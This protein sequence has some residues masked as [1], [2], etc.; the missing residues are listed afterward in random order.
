MPPTISSVCKNP[1]G[2]R[3]TDLPEIK[4]LREV[5]EWQLYVHPLGRKSLG[6]MNDTELYLRRHPGRGSTHTF[7]PSFDAVKCAHNTTP[8]NALNIQ[9]T[10]FLHP[11]VLWFFIHIN[12]SIF[13]CIRN[14]AL[15]LPSLGHVN[16]KNTNNLSESSLSPSSF[17]YIYILLL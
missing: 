13:P 3:R 6:Y 14:Y 1:S 11:I 12:R 2:S 4:G 15:E 9:T 8:V 16:L 10:S 7:K 17:Y 5:I